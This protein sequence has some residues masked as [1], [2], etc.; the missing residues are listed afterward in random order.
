[1]KA[2]H[3]LLGVLAATFMLTS[4]AAAGADSANQRVAAKQRVV[5]SIKNPDGG[6]FVLTPLQAG[7]LKRD[8]GT[9]SVV[10]TEEP[11][12]MRDGQ[13]VSTARNTYTFEGK[14]GRLTIRDRAEWVIVSNEKAPGTDYKP[15]VGMGT[16]KI[17]GGTGAYAKIS[18]GGRSGHQGHPVWLVCQEGFLT[19]R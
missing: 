4:A 9:V 13:T 3:A 8:S 17:V 2:R 1:M 18:G 14:R 5:I 19:L 12:V 6:T 16:W 11:D 10:Y 7:P 15:G